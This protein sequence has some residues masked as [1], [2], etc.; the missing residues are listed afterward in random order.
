M[1]RDR[2]DNSISTPSAK[3]RDLYVEAVDRLLAGAPGIVEGFAAV[4]EAAPDFALA[5]GGLARARHIMGDVVGA[6]EALAAANNLAKG[7]SQR[8]ASHLHV[9]G[10]LI[11]GKVADAYPAIRAH[12]AEHPR[13]VVV[14]QTCTSIFG[15]IGLSGQPGREAELLAYTTTLAPHY[16]ED[17]WFLSQ[18]AFSLVET[19][20]TARAAAMVDRSLALNPR[21]AHAAH[22]RA[23][24]HY[25]AGEATAGLTFLDRWLENYPND[26]IIHG[27]LSWHVALWALGQGNA[28]L[29]WRTIDT[30][31]AP[32]ATS[33]RPL[34]VLSDNASVLFRANLAGHAVS[35]ERWKA[36]SDFAKRAFPN[37]GIG[38]ADLHAALAHAMAGD[39]KT[40][41]TIIANAAG[42]AADLVREAAQA[43][44]AYADQDWA[45]ATRHLIAAMAD[46]A[47]IGGSRAQRD[48]LE[49]TLL[50]ALSNQG[51]SQEARDLLALRRPVMA[52]AHP[53]RGL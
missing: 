31:I 13:D 18:H 42:P 38:F 30:C 44:R 16:Q 8:E 27:H 49:F 26:G 20:Q 15:L 45:G 46:H 50:A 21:N 7:L 37:T 12:V 36:I 6:R 52:A 11:E 29:M 32:G 41:D 48:L 5:H 23:H 40:L 2:Y 17:W 28:D 47:R 3:A 9:L 43:Y 39:R 4:T 33:G 35:A 34:N 24:V 53:V 22:V 1:L 14:A 19:G 10:L 51:R 25:E